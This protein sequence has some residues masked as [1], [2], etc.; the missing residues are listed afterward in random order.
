M[1]YLL[2]LGLKGSSSCHSW[3]VIGLGIEEKG[4]AYVD[5][6]KTLC[7]SDPSEEKVI[8]FMSM[9]ILLG[10]SHK[11]YHIIASSKLLPSLFIWISFIFVNCWL[12]SWSNI[13]VVLSLDVVLISDEL[14]CFQLIFRDLKASNILLDEDFKA[15]LSDFGLA[16]QGPTAG[17][18]HVSTSV[19]FMYLSVSFSLL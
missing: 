14:F 5:N 16:R 17:F 11:S 7:M 2:K 10:S 12:M 1:P 8:I 6:L 15:K 19:S 4:F 13:V 3:L 18:G 9:H